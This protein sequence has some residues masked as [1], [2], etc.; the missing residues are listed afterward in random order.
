M[1]DDLRMP[2]QE[3][4]ESLNRLYGVEEAEYVRPS[5]ADP[6]KPP[7]HCEQCG[8]PDVHSISKLPA[9][10]LFLVVI[11]SLGFAVDLMMAAFL[12]A[13]AGGIFFL[14]APRWRCAS[15]GYRWSS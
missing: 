6:P 14:I 13:L 2:Q 15:C 5:A 9:Y 3:D 11:F 4:D 8:S 1:S 7:S 12:L 10:A